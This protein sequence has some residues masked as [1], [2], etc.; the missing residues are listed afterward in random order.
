MYFPKTKDPI[1]INSAKIFLS[2]YYTISK[3]ITFLYS[4]EFKCFA[5]KFLKKKLKRSKIKNKSTKKF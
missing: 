3:L 2:K 1:R 5:L 4:T